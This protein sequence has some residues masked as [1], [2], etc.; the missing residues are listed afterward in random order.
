[1]NFLDAAFEILTEAQAPLHYSEIAKKALMRGILDTSGQTPE[2]TMGSRLYVDTNRPDSRFRR[3]GRGFFEL[4]KS[5]LTDEIGHRVE[6]INRQTRLRLRQTLSDMPAD[7]FEALIGELLRA[8]G[9]DEST[10]HVTRY[11]G[12]RG[13]DVRGELNAGGVTR[14]RAAVQAKKWKHNVQATTVREVRGSLTA[15]E[16]GII[17]TTSN[18]STGARQEANAIGK[19]PISLVNGDQ[20]LELLV[21]HEIGVTK[22]QH[23]V[24][25]LDEEWWGEVTGTPIEQP[26][27]SLIPEKTQPVQT[28]AIEFPLNVRA[29]NDPEK[30][31]ILYDLNGVMTY[32]GERYKSV[33]AAGQVASGWKS[34]NGWSFWH[35]QDP[36]TGQWHV[37]QQLRG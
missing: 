26:P 34:C 32:D 31:A 21:E 25:S 23:T 10:V 16:Q 37:I 20:L 27:V 8:I 9:F 2:A 1:M 18:F 11:S 17:I 5:G 4:V 24:I 19:S 6:D 35:F 15:Q 3:S 29:G 7:R 33:S 22:L 30:V 13:I 28:Y 36:A 12:D 14:I